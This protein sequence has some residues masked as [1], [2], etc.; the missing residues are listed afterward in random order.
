V[1]SLLSDDIALSSRNA[2]ERSQ[3]KQHH[4]V[5]ERVKNSFVFVEAKKQWDTEERFKKEK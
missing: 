1:L 3:M 5:T 2:T 4:A